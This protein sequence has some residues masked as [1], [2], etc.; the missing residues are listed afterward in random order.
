MLQRHWVKRTGKENH[1]CTE[2]EGGSGHAIDHSVY[3]YFEVP[4][5]A[6]AALACAPSKGRHFNQA[7]R[8]KFRYDIQSA[9]SER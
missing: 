3:R 6:Y 5:E 9:K 2:R 7:I 1:N 8:G 4:F